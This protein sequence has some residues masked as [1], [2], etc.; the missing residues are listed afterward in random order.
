V[1]QRLEA[2][3]PLHV[4]LNPLE[5]LWLQGLFSTGTPVASHSSSGDVERRY[6]FSIGSAL[7][8]PTQQHLPSL[9]I[10]TEPS[11][12]HTPQA[13]I[14]LE[15][16]GP[17]SSAQRETDPSTA[18]N[19]DPYTQSLVELYQVFQDYDETSSGLSQV[20]ISRPEGV[21]MLLEADQ[22]PSIEVLDLTCHEQLS[23]NGS[24]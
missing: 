17:S 6:S 13:N 18:P 3:A 14:V 24:A 22:N 16:A 8:Q 7:S 20:E 23:G 9:L 21:L 19:R 10:T 15:P 12:V 2:I 1:E 5:V 11:Q 4:Q